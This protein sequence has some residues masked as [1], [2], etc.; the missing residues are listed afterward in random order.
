MYSSFVGQSSTKKSS[1]RQ[2]KLSFSTKQ[3]N[4]PSAPNPPKIS[5]KRIKTELISDHGVEDPTSDASCNGVKEGKEKKKEAR[6]SD[7]KTEE[8]DPDTAAD[9]M[10]GR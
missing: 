5:E 1:N 6:Q 4:E 9:V 10:A 3:L 7:I 2:S 8:P